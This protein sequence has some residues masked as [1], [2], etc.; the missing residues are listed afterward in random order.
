MNK[1]VHPVVCVTAGFFLILWL[2]LAEGRSL[3]A[4][5]SCVLAAGIFFARNA[6]WRTLARLRYIFLALLVLFLWETPGTLIFPVLGNFSPSMDGLWYFL[7]HSIRLAGVVAVVTLMLSRLSS[8][9]WVASLLTIS[10]PLRQAGFATERFAAR[11]HLVLEYAQRRELD[12][13]QI[14]HERIGDYSEEL[15]MEDETLEAKDRWLL[16]AVCCCGMWGGYWLG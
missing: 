15:P 13:R 11:L 1:S 14:L 7:L 4:G 9:E 10:S 6:L 2:Q 3:Y 16:F 5:A 8:A 12:W